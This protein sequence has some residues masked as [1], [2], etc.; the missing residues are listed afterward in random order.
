MSATGDSPPSGDANER[1][2]VGEVGALSGVPHALPALM[3]ASML[4]KRAARVGFDWRDERAVRPKIAEELRETE[5]AISQQDPAA[6]TE[7]LGDTLFALVNWARLLEVDPETALREA[8][9][10]F[11]RRFA[12]MEGLISR[13]GLA[14]ERLTPEA[15]ES[16]WNEVKESE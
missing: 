11:E 2:A 6:V 9:H 16:L 13:R 14:I 8:N 5:V 4:G 1:A 10:K 3:R 7:E 15:W 12:A